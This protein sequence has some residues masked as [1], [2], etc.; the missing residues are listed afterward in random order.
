MIRRS[1]TLA[2]LATG[3]MS[4]GGLL[5]VTEGPASA[6]AVTLYVGPS[7][8]AAA[9]SG[10]ETPESRRSNKLHPDPRWVARR[11]RLRYL[12]N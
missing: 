12:G 3:V 6:S 10:R 7:G 2:L 4:L 8:T 1:R 5:A 9:T 11:P